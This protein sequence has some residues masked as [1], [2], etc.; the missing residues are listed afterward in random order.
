[1]VS[2]FIETEETRRSIPLMCRVLRVSRPGYYAWRERPPSSRE[3]EDAEL[4]G[5]IG[6]IH[7]D[8]RGTYGAPRVHAQLRSEGV[9]V[10][11][12]RVARLMRKEGLQGCHHRC[13]KTPRTTLR[14]PRATPAEDLVERDFTP[15]A[16]DRLWVADV[17]YAP[18]WGG[19]DYLAFIL[20]AYSGR[21]VGWAMA[22]H[23]RAGL[24]TD[25]L[26]MAVWRR[27]PAPGLTHH[28]GQGSQYTSISLGRKLEEAGIAPST[29]SVADPYDNALAESFVSSLKRE[30]VERRSWPTRGAV[31]GAM[32]EYFEVFYNRKRIHSALGCQSPADYERSTM[33]EGVAA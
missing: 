5:R 8:S 26:G 4:T 15:V 11:N 28:S 1:M 17:P 22:D 23:L 29:G 16:K 20:D 33:E 10:G 24:V 12:K 27:N 31:R 6:R 14:D 19:F 3:R 2:S 7:R 9:R 25:A 30:L 21:L 13:R 32:F 18:T